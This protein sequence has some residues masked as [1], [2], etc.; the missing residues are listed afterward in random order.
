[1][2]F[3]A[4]ELLSAASAARL[5]AT[6]TKTIKPVMKNPGRCMVLPRKSCQFKREFLLHNLKKQQP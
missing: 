1:M 5:S 3:S 4:D 6:P 2:M